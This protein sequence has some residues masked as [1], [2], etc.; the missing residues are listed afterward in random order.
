MYTEEPKLIPLKIKELVPKEEKIYWTGRPEWRSLAYQSF[1][2]KYLIVYFFICGLYALTSLE[3]SFDFRLV[4]L[5]FFPFAVSGSFAGIILAIIAYFEATH[6]FYV[7]TERR[8]VLKS[9]VALVFILNAPFKKIISIDRQSL[10]GGRGNIAFST[11]STKRIPYISC[12]PSVKPWSFMSPIPSFRS[13]K[14]VNKVESLLREITNAGAKS[15]NTKID[16]D[17]NAMAT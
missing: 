7:L 3:N 9:G 1:G 5:N 15:D 11:E 14:D 10:A 8:I 12:W 6:T 16:Q 17:R 4:L 2:L 13:I